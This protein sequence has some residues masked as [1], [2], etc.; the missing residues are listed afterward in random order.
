M[1]RLVI[2]KVMLSCEDADVEWPSVVDPAQ[3]APKDKRPKPLGHCGF[4][5][6]LM[7]LP[8]DRLSFTAIASGF[9][10]GSTQT[11]LYNHRR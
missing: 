3:T 7:V 9:R 8:Q 5:Q 2:N 4:R 11:R 10:P 6:V 1:T